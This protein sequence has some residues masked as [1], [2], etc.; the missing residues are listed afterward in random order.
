MEVKKIII[1]ILKW[2]G[3]VVG[4]VLLLIF[5]IPALFPGTISEQ[6][7]IFANMHLAGKL[8]YKKSHLTFFR[9]F[10][11]LTVSADDF[12]LKGS[13]PFQNDTL[14]SA[15]E[16][17]V[18]I[19]LK[20]LIFNR[21]IKIDEIY[22][23]DAY[24]NVFVNS[25]GEAN[26]NV[27]IAKPS[28]KPKDTTGTGTSIKLDLIKLRNW[29]IKYNDH[30]ARVLVDAR[31]L[32][33]TGKGG[34]SEDI[35]DLTT[36]L[37][38]DKLDFSLNR[39]YYAKQKSL[40]ADL[41][42]RI[43]TNALTFVLRKN[44]LRINDLPLKFTG[45]LSVLKDGYNLD[46]N[47]ASENTTVRN[48]ISVLPPQYLE[49]AKD[50]KIEGK[51]DLFFS[52]KG[53]FSEPKNLKP[54]L[55]A[56][57]MVKDG[58]VS[59]G[60]APVPMNNFNM[61]MNVD[62]PDLN[63]DQL[64][65]DL[66]NL[67]FDLGKN[68]NFKAVVRTKGLDEM[69]VFADVKGAVNL[70]TLS[71][72]LGLKNMEVKGL[73]DTNIK[74]NGLFSLDKKLFP[75]T[76]GYLNVKNGWLKTK[77]Y[78]NPI[79][80]IQ[81][82]ANVVNTDGTFKSLGV[83]LHPFTFDFE[84]NPVFVNADLQNFE[85]V[86]YKVRAKGVLNVGRI[87]KVFARKGFDVNGLIMAD[88]SLNGRQS[89]ATTGQYN[90]LDNRG[91]LILKNIKATTEYLPKSFYIKEGNFQFEN[92][93]MWFRKFLTTY[94]KSDF[95]LNG[96]L[97]N[98]INYFIE[99]KGMLH[100]KF[101]L[102]SGYILIDEFMALKNGDNADKAIEVDYAKAENPNS[103]GVVIVPKNLDV[104]LEADAKTV[105]FKG[106]KLSNVFGLASVD[107]GQVY[108]K[109]TSLNVVGSRMNIDA[110]YQDE[111]PITANYDIALKV[112]DFDVQRAYR[113]IDMVREMATAAK[114]VKGIVSLDYKLKGDFDKDMK[115][116][117]PSLE[118]GGVVNLR[119][120]E[121]KN[122]KMLSAVGDNIGAKA[123]NDP[124]MKGVNIETH[125]KNN[126]IHVDKFTFKVSILRPTISGT[127]S[128][129]GLLD[130]RI[131]V[132]ILPGG[133]IGFPV[134]VTGTHEKPKVK[135]FSKTG[136]GI[137]DA[138]YNQKSNKVIRQERRA[139]K[140]TRRQQRKEKEA[141]EQ[142]AKAAEKTITKDLKEKN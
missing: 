34:L 99:R 117:Y 28:E 71:Q 122:L 17:A 54:R 37:D 67:S 131:R 53:R 79:K 16:V 26:Y 105:E 59:S 107:K 75:K 133:I 88:V 36:Y 68:N 139:E 85:D 120:V 64:G 22:V 125:I 100:G 41:I 130:L 19:N 108:L 111:S 134:V 110:R 21:Q 46:I 35:F 12:L 63:T 138:L 56:R 69:Q 62:F 1:K 60:K 90:R 113:E 58:F 29:N 141:Q 101:K 30:S 123:F 137:I 45:F 104:S 38:I 70:Q 23:T 65:L 112:R 83:Q 57:L 49:W 106:L 27:Y 33:Y 50:T 31:G 8:D 9:H 96:Y 43:N 24:A 140:K 84:G 142:K 44:E 61:D 25:K 51:S 40:H 52:L 73:L 119:D 115:P 136:Q 118:G 135:I 55:Q 124:D 74:A 14:L 127:T 32:D 7:K 72:A 93:K 77:Y 94:G 95:A 102:K 91:N 129:N 98:T 47:A 6:V 92:E 109:N 87:Y 80:D 116:I 4:S 18:G 48:M 78:P 15:R 86:L 20:N 97:L 128:F 114:S 3:I 11:S 13:K 10:P 132:G 89:Y 121:V 39:T 5:I 66:K 42:T 82:M 2:T 126:L 76:Q 103:S 81:I